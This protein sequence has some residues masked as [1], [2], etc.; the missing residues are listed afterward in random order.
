[1]KKD[2]DRLQLCWRCEHRARW[3]ET[4]GKHQPRY[5]CGQSD[6]AVHA[7]YMFQPCKPV[8]IERLLSYKDDPRPLAPGYF[9]TRF[10]AVAVAECSM[11]VK[12]TDNQPVFYWEPAR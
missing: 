2:T 5:E 7:C 12:G 4:G 6:S 1:M 8:V 3:W 11:R 9:S 10:H